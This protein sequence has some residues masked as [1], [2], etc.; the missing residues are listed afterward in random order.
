[1]P[2]I[3]DSEVSFPNSP[4]VP[5][6]N[7]LRVS[8]LKLCDNLVTLGQISPESPSP[9]DPAWRARFLWE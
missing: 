7:R 2:F 4:P 1:M 5:T 8:H 9:K 6:L 3:G